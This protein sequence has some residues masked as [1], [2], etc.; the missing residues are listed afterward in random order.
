[1]DVVP[2]RGVLLGHAV[3]VSV[4]D[5]GPLQRQSA[6]HRGALSTKLS[7][8]NALEPCEGKG[9]CPKPVP[10]SI[11]PASTQHQPSMFLTVLGQ[12][13]VEGSVTETD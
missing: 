4:R 2:S 7:E 13:G 9:A 12:P 5:H 8:W 6:E 1:M 11:D 3:T 10:L